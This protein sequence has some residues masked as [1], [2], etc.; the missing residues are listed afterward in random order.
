[1]HI[2]YL[3][4]YVVLW[5]LDAVF[6]PLSRACVQS[7]PKQVL[8]LN[9]LRD[10]KDM[11]YQ[12]MPSCASSVPR[13]DRTDYTSLIDLANT[14][15]VDDSCSTSSKGDCPKRMPG[16]G[17][18]DGSDSEDSTSSLILGPHHSN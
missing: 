13:D 12:Q 3:F 1:M 9:E 14:G 4:A 7:Y 16:E 6:L 15:P 18:E 17:T 8:T 10:V 5:N 11:A 2:S